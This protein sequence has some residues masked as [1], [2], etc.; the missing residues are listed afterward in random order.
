MYAYLK[1]DLA[2]K[3]PTCV[4]LETGGIGYEVQISLFTY[5]KIEAMQSAQLYIQQIV[6]EDSHT[7]YG[8]YD[9]AE[10][11]LFN[12]L[13]SVSGIGPNTGRLIL[14]GMQPEEVQNAIL[15]EDELSFKKVKGV[16]PKTA[17]RLIVELKDKL[18]RES[19]GATTTVSAQPQATSAVQEAMSALIALGFQKTQVRKALEKVHPTVGPDAE[20]EQWVKLA[21]KELSG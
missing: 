8:F 17:K 4:I 11:T 9:E 16:G 7:L 2:R 5:S 6:R 3:T 18:T 15:S 20:T 12:H 13:I 14:S 1:G 21:L 19:L 10:K